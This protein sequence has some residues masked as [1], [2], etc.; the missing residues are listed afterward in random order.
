MEQICIWNG[1]ISSLA[2]MMNSG[3]AYDFIKKMPFEADAT[4]LGGSDGCL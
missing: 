2:L 1:M 4:V 3:E